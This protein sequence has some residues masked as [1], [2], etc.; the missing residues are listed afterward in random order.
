[1]KMTEDRRA[2]IVDEQTYLYYYYLLKDLAINNF[3]WLNL[4]DE[5]DERFIELTLFEKGYGLFFKDDV[6]DKYLFLPCTI[7][8]V[9]DN[10]RIP[11]YRVA[12]GTNGYTYPAD[13]ENSVIVF[14]NYMHT[15][16]ELFCRMY[17]ERLMNCARTIDVNINAQKT[18]YIIVAPEEAKFSIRNIFQKI[19][20]YVNYILTTNYF[21]SDSIKTFN[22]TAPY[23]ADKIMATK[24]QLLNEA[25]TYLGIENT[26]DSKKERQVTNE[27]NYALGN[28]YANRI[29]RL[30]ARK[31]ACEKFNNMY[32]TNIDVR[33]RLPSTYADSLY[34]DELTSNLE[35]MLSQNPVK[36]MGSDDV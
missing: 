10:Y 23:V 22:T 16:D 18:P 28:V 3:E 4:P 12:I 31:Q 33:F 15:P 30:N 35:N 24:K 32:G 25:L 29:R 20:G 19:Q 26:N 14:N 9:L 1:M 36:E 5:I 27:V 2:A 6:M 8:G 7:G 11:T 34:K 13:N 21:K 17:T